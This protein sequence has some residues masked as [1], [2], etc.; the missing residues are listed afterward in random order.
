MRENMNSKQIK[1]LAIGNGEKEKLYDSY[2]A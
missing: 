1:L 2:N